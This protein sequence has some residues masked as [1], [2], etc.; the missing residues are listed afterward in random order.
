MTVEM[1]L[2]VFP[3]PGRIAAYAQMAEQDGWDGIAVTDS[4]TNNGDA[5]CALNVAGY[6]TSRIKLTTSATNA[7]TRHPSVIASAIATV[8][9]ES[10]GRAVLGIGRGDSSVRSIGREPMPLGEFQRALEQIQAYLRGETVDYDG[11]TNRMG[12]IEPYGLPKVP[13]SVSA[14][15]PRTIAIGA[16]V[17]DRLTFSLGAEI[18]RLEWA[19]ELARTTRARAGLDPTTISLGAY[20]NAA[21][22]P[23][24][25]RA[26]EL[27]RPRLNT[28]ARHWTMHANAR[29]TLS[30]ED[31]ALVDRV[32]RRE[33]S[34]SDDFV[35][36]HAVAGT[37]D[38]VVGRLAQ[39]AA[40]GLDHL[41]VVGYAGN[42][43]PEA[44]ADGSQRFG[45]EVIPALK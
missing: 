5:F 35:E 22:H 21:A 15:G 26:I 1:W 44:L 37:S 43:A 9:A 38:Y 28:Y 19:I 30:A 11:Y 41:I 12:W 36:R 39:M 45:H 6:A 4:Q 29:K 24:P 23:D 3:I 7:V 20:V 2:G 25:A 18:E 17:A 32:K 27:V 8:H 42:V 13:M 10:K 31:D 16:L 33:T 34:L 40:L 14:T